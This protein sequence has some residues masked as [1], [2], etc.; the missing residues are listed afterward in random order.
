MAV[1]D[2]IK[3]LTRI[4]DSLQQIDQCRYFALPVTD[5]EA[6]GYHT[7]LQSLSHHPL[8]DLFSRSLNVQCVSQQCVRKWR[9]IDIRHGVNSS[10][11]LT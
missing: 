11:T 8:S 10:L 2:P 5:A 7:V 6:P 1:F 9:T 3:V 4:L